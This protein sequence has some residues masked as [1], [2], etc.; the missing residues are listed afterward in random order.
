[1]S[2]LWTSDYKITL[3]TANIDWLP[4]SA[5][6][7]SQKI[8][9]GFG[10]SEAIECTIPEMDFLTLAAAKDWNIKSAEQFSASMRIEGLPKLREIP[11]IGPADIVLRGYEYQSRASNGGGVSV[12]FDCDLQRMIYET[13]DR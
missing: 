1:M 5:K 8:R 9:T 4:S 3:H 10:A 13:S 7:V 6:D 12:W 11:M 2:C